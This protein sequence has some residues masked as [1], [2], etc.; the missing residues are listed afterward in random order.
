MEERL[1]I[2]RLIR[3][4][5]LVKALGTSSSTL[6]KWR[7]EGL[8]WVSIGGKVF[9]HETDFMEWLLKHKKRM[10]DRQEE[11]EV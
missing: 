1:R 9:Y 2:E 10:A 4:G 6:S 8:P 3:E 11:K 7:S 5:Q